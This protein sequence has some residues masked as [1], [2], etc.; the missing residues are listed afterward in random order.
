MRTAEEKLGPVEAY[1][2]YPRVNFQRIE[3]FADMALMSDGKGGRTKK[4]RRSLTIH[5]DV[6]FRQASDTEWDQLTAAL[7]AEDWPTAL[8]VL[9]AVAGPLPGKPAEKAR[10]DAVIRAAFS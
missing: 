7:A 5:L 3:D 4:P 10:S 6:P 9:L 2:V 1:G 8:A